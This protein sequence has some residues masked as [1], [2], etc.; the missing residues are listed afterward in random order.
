LAL[1]F[2]EIEATRQP[3]T[4]VSLLTSGESILSVGCHSV[5]QLCTSLHANL[6]SQQRTK[7]PL[8]CPTVS[9]SQEAFS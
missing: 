1:R 7:D 8:H 4:L 2:S 3:G 6:P 9:S 5:G